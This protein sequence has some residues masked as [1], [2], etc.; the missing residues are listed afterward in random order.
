LRDAATYIQFAVIDPAMQ[1]MI[2]LL[3]QRLADERKL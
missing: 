1:E 2:G 3:S